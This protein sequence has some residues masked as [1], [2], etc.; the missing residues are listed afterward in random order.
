MYALCGRLQS[1]A[2]D[3]RG[4]RNRGAGYAVVFAMALLWA[5]SA[6]PPVLA[7]DAGPDR[8]AGAGSASELIAASLPSASAGLVG[9][10]E[11]DPDDVPPDGE[12][13]PPPTEDE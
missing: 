3:S 10:E 7:S 12:E 9:R 6:A 11:G 13:D 4:A 5:L 2:A 1:A 8:V